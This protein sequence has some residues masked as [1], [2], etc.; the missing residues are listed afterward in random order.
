MEARGRPRRVEENEGG[1]IFNTPK[2]PTGIYENLPAILRDS[3]ELFQDDIEKD[4]F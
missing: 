3:A 4:V 1:R 2:L